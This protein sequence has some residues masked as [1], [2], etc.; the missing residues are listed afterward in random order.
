MDMLM[1]I[2]ITIMIVVDIFSCCYVVT[3][4]NGTYPNVRMLQAYSSRF[5][6]RMFDG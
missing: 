6:N 2:K 1:V 3:M 5:N 4:L